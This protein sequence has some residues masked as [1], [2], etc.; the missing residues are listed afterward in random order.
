VSLLVLFVLAAIAVRAKVSI[1]LAGF[2][3]GLAVARVGEPR[4]LAKQLFGLTEGLF[5]PLFF[6]WVGATID[7]RALGAHPKYLLLGFALA[8]AAIVAHAAMRVTG[9]PVLLGMVAAAQL[10]VPIAAVTLGTQRHL[11]HPGEAAALLLA[12]LLTV[13]GTTVAAA[14]AARR[15]PPAAR[16]A[17]TM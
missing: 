1:M 9:Q 17:P 12:A 8:L 10:G 6:V 15:T 16:P 5:A 13:A 11:L 2:A 3:L 14:L 4:R 7:V